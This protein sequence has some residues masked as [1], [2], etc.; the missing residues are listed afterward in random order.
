MKAVVI[1]EEIRAGM[2]AHCAVSVIGVTKVG[3]TDLND[4]DV[5][6]VVGPDHE[7]IAG[8]RERA[9]D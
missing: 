3:S 2:Q 7:L 5:A 9:Q 6:I 1:A 4:A 8:E